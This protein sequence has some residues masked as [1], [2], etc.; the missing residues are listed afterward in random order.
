MN[1][2]SEQYQPLIAK[3]WA[4]EAFKQRLLADPAGTLK[5]EGLEVPAGV[6]VQ[7]VENT[8]GMFTL[9]I[10]ARATALSDEELGSLAGGGY[11]VFPPSAFEDN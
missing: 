2:Q 7:V 9:V 3:C 10:P 11:Q 8:A 1:D 6:R 5:A 4:D